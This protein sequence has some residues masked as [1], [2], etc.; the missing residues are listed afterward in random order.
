MTDIFPKLWFPEPD[1]E[2]ELAANRNEHT[3]DWLARCTNWKAKECRRFLNES[4]AL[5]RSDAVKSFEINSRPRWKSAYFELVVARTL[6]ALG[7]TLKIE[8]ANEAGKRPDFTASYADG[9]VIVEAVSPV[10]NTNAG[11]KMEMQ[12]PL[13]D[14][15]EKRIPTGVRCGV[16][17]LPDIGLADSKKEFKAAV[18]LIFSNLPDSVDD[19]LEIVKELSNGDIRITILPGESR[20]RR[21]A[22][23]PLITVF[24][25]SEDRIRNAVNRKKSQVRGSKEPVLLAIDASGLS[26]ELEDF[27]MALFGHTFE[28]VDMNGQT[29]ETGF[30]ANGLF[31][32]RREGDPT[33]AGVLAFLEVGFQKCTDPV[34]YIHPRFSGGL[35]SAFDVLECRSLNRGTNHIVVRDRSADVMEGLNFVKKP[36][37]LSMP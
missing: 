24:D 3:L 36:S 35:P 7:A 5:L 1:V 8:A 26:S 21:V 4:L 19:R 17:E 32:T 34:L 6:Q 31:A 10:F 22:I 2:D 18:E 25:N 14:V 29:V 13:L 33:Y 27:D 16:W 11:E 9:S 20:S 15:I 23:E 37:E 28:R 30:D 12:K